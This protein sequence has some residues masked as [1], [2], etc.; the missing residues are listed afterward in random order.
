MSSTET[1]GTLPSPGATNTVNDAASTRAGLSNRAAAVFVAAGIALSLLTVLVPSEDTRSFLFDALGLIAASGAVYGIAHNRPDRR[2]AWQLF[3]LALVLFAAGDVIFD[4]AQRGFGHADGYPYSDVAYLAAYPVLAIA[5]YQLARTRFRRDTTIDSAIVAIALSAVIWQWVITPVFDTASSATMER[6]VAV[7]Y[8]IMDIVLVVVIV[9]AVFTLPRWTAAAWFLFAGLAV[10]LVADA[11]F[12]RL[13]ADGTY[14][15]GGA[16]DTLWPVSYFLL[17]GAVLHP[18]LRQLWS[19]EQAGLVEH[20]RARMVVLGGALFAAPAVVLLDDSGSGSAVILAAVTGVAAALVAWRIGRLVTESNQAREVLA[21]SEARFRALVQHA[22]DVIAVMSPEGYVRYISPAVVDVFGRTSDELTGQLF[23]GFLNAAGMETATQV[24]AALL[25]HPDR[26]AMAEYEVWDGKDWHW[27]EATWTNQLDVPAV[28]GFVGNI[29]EISERKR[30]EALNEAETTVLELILSGAPVPEILGEVLTA[31]EQFVP[32]SSCSIR[33]A[34][35]EGDRLRSVAA[36]SLPADFVSGVEALVTASEVDEARPGN[37]LV[38][39][40]DLEKTTADNP[41]LVALCTTHGLRSA[42]TVP[43]R[44]PETSDFLGLLALYL[45]IAREPNAAELALM[46]RARDL[47]ALAIDRAEHTRK[48]G[49]L[50]LHDTLTGLPNRAL[51]LDRL[52]HA[53]A[54]LAD[55]DSAVAVLFIDLD[56]FKLVN[57]GLGHETGDE[58]LVAVSRRLAATVRRQDTVARLGGDEFV[59]LCEDLTDEDQAA[60]LAERAAQAFA[61]PFRLSHAE[62]TVSASIGIA[63]TGRSS[64]RAPS[65]L[66]DADAAMYRA[67]RRGGAR[68]E[69]FD[70]AMH[71]QAVSRLLTERALRHALDNDELRVVY[72][73]QFDLSDGERVS[74][75]GLLRWEHPARGLIAPDDFIRVAEETGIIVPIGRWVLQQACALARSSQTDG[76]NGG[77]L[78]V[79]TNLSV[80]ELQR[81]DLPAVVARAVADYA[82]DPAT[83]CLEVSEV[84]L[85]DDLDAVSEALRTLKDLGVRLAIDDFGTGGSSLTY[86]RRFPFDELKVDRSFIAGLGRSAA[87]D[88]IVAA[89]IDMAHALGMVVAAEGVETEEQ[90][91]RLQDLGCDRAQGYYLA[92]PEKMTARR[93]VLIEQ[94]PA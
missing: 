8:P 49:Y 26:P 75:E 69:L 90:L 9:H 17:A 64:D 89:T 59:V 45:S 58:L 83:L 10:M 24:H 50:A 7:A 3:A 77:A 19:S 38:V 93:L 40:R 39:I 21:E 53:L 70:E 76:P 47:V 81:P 78:A 28:R 73:P 82:V 63:V 66:R 18:S 80:R 87:D 60:E 62:V 56:R 51:A 15:D 91:A 57:D 41:E 55:T 48:L 1:A 67:K 74:V 36:P 20:G 79:S 61:Q 4:V 85:F 12:A 65:L 14:T 32:E 71:T 31:I 68:H 13:V 86:L 33:L 94:R 44:D 22:A 43:I 23:R 37:E 42:W 6:I 92:E 84:S 11:A 16:L 54:R 25:E 72:Q 2:G 35:G 52:E 29:R 27:I 5:L 30:N 46:E 34:D 88:A